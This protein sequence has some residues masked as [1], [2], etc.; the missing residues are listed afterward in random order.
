MVREQEER[1]MV[2]PV[3]ASFVGGQT[4]LGQGLL[5]S[6]RNS[7]GLGV[8]FGALHQVDTRLAVDLFSQLI[9]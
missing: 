1:Q 4:H 5:H 9:G 2:G 7:L 8:I 6:L 3:R